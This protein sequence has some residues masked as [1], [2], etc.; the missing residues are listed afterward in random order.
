[1]KKSRTIMIVT[2]LAPALIMFAMIFVYPIIRTLV[3]SVYSVPHVT[4]DVS[5]WEFVGLK[6]FIRLLDS[7]LFVT[8]LWN[9][10]RIWLFGGAA[11]MLISLIFAAII[12]SGIRFKGFFKAVIYMP[13]VI[14]AV[15]LA[16]MW[17]QYVFNNRYGLLVT[18][19]RKIGWEAMAQ[20]QWLSP[21]MKFTALIIA[22]CF[23]MVGYHMLIF[24]SGIE[25][26]PGDLYEA[27]WIDGANKVKQFFRITLPLIKGVFKTNVIMWSITSAGF[28][29]WSQLFSTVT[30]DQQT[31]T[32]MVYL[33]AQTFGTGNTITERDAGIGAAVG[34]M[35]AI[36]VILAFVATNSLLKNDDLEY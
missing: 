23:G 32:P 9:L 22:Y 20:V 26:I 18:F 35:L 19:F 4:A 14:S 7:N 12:N 31:V 15:A 33:Y 29:I 3:M 11:V 13:N 6:N 34:V 21:D 36:F 24:S 10:F 25:R 27:S 8:S 1:M 28:F 17:Q 30:A 2:F 5:T 16:T